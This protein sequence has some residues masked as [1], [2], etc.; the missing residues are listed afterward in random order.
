MD[1][2]APEAKSDKAPHMR[3]LAL[4]TVMLALGACQSGSNISDAFDTRQN[5]GACPPTGAIYQAAR[6]VKFEG[7]QERFSNVQYTGEIVDVRMFCRYADTDPVRAEIEIDFAFGKGA[8]GVSDRHDY[9]YWVAVTRRSGKVLNKKQFTVQADFSEGPVTGT[10]EVLQE[11]IIPR[12]DESV[13]AANFEILIGFDLTESQR[14][15]NAEG[16]RFR[17]GAGQ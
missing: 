1:S 7:D 16:R 2:L 6:V 8:A 4:S 15:Y 13:S 12:A 17:L 10:T 3:L 11:I 9:G 5:A 14:T